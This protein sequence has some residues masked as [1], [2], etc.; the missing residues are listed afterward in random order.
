MIISPLKDGIIRTVLV[1]AFWLLG[2]L[3]VVHAGRVTRGRG[4]KLFLEHESTGLLSSI[5]EN[6]DLLQRFLL[7]LQWLEQ[8]PLLVT[9]GLSELRGK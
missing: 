4:E 7:L 3:V 1:S 6:P 9:L 8:I 2:I 5:L